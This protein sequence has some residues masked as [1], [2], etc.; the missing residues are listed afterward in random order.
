MRAFNLDSG[1]QFFVRFSRSPSRMGAT[2]IL[3]LFQGQFALMPQAAV[4]P[5]SGTLMFFA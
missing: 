2:L 5:E 1:N 3:Q 4:A